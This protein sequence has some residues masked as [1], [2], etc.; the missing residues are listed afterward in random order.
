MQQNS[1]LLNFIRSAKQAGASDEFLVMLLEDS[2]WPR[3][4]IFNALRGH[5][6]DL[7][8]QTIPPRTTAAES[9]RDAFLYLLSFSM[10]ATWAWA[11]GSL[12][13]YF[14]D[15]WFPD[16]VFN[17]R[18]FGSNY[19]VPFHMAAILIAFPVYLL[20]MRSIVRGVAEQP[21]KL[22]SPVRKWLTYIALLFAAGFLI[23]DAITFLEY[24]LRGELSLRFIC[25]V[26]IVVVIAGGIFGYYLDSVRSRAVD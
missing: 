4:H 1:E 17:V 24:L 14:I 5:Y 25:K 16:P 9:S 3:K 13:F 22:E 2:R 12:M 26:A 15:Q 23:G 6:E 18:P 7:A 11:L 8:G 19:T 20:V 21:E 10:L